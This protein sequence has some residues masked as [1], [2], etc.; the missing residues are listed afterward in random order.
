[1]RY[2]MLLPALASAVPAWSADINFAGVV[3]NACILTPSAGTLGPEG[4]GR[5]L[6]SQGLGGAPATLAVIATGGIPSLTF[7][8]PVATTPTGFAGSV[9]PGISYTSTGGIL[10]ALTATTSTKALNGLLDLVTVQGRIASTA[11]FPSGSYGV[12][13]TVT[14][15]Q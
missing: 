11:G 8:A 6:S 10:Q 2:W 13:T 4:D 7:S 15:Q 9:T 14:C 5:T 3:V 1:M 12:R